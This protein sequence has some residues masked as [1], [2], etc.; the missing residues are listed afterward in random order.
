MT[1]LIDNVIGPSEVSLVNF[2]MGHLEIQASDL[3]LQLS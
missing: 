1:A 2:I 3:Q